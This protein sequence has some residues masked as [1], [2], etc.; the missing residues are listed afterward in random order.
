[1]DDW[2]SINAQTA[3]LYNSNFQCDSRRLEIRKPYADRA[4]LLASRGKSE[5]AI[6]KV[7]IQ[8]EE[9][10][11]IDLERCKAI[12]DKPIYEVGPITFYKCPCQYTHPLYNRIH[13]LA[14][15]FDKG[16]LPHSGG[17]MEQEATTMALIETMNT[18]IQREKLNSEKKQLE[19]QL[20]NRG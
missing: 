1:M 16:V 10:L 2:V 4:A 13:D 7:L 19:T 17:Y 11:Q 18:A 3:A 14:V 20:K 8:A 6:S 9:A 15:L 5:E 12:S